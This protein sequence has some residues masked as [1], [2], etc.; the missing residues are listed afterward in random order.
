MLANGFSEYSV[1]RLEDKISGSNL[2]T[3]I[4]GSTV[5][6]AFNSLKL[7]A[8]SFEIELRM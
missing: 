7:L 1:S 2:Y 8:L 5:I 6:E 3:T 4:L